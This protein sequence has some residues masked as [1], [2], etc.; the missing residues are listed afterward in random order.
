ME[1]ASL[2]L[3]ILGALFAALAVVL[4]LYGGGSIVERTWT[5]TWRLSSNEFD[6]PVFKRG[7][8]PIFFRR[9]ALGLVI[10]APLLA[11]IAYQRAHRGFSIVPGVTWS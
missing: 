3:G 8:L 11:F 9:L 1:L 6:G 10:L 4:M 7:G 5:R 2:L